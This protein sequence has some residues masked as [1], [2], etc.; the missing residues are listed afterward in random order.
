M[1]AE[2]INRIFR[3]AAMVAVLPALLVCAG[4]QAVDCVVAHVNRRA[5]TL[6]DVR[7]LSAFHLGETSAPG[8]KAPTPR[9]ILQKSIDRRVVI[10]LLRENFPVSRDDVD[11]RFAGLKARFEPDEWRRLIDTFGITESAIESYLEHILQ[12]ER[13]IAIRFGQPPD[14]T[15]QEIEDYYTQEYAPAQRSSGL[16]PQP[17]SQVLGEIEERLKDRK[18]EAQI[19]DWVHGL[20]AQAE[21][22]IN[23]ECL[24][25]LK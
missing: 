13:M 24:Q 4:P 11:A 7:I 6:T 22:S 2:P 23:E 21:I 9:E 12:Y 25:H 3:T 15:V 16:E 20:R 1:L 17:M 19:S 8:A 18:R 14:V 10:E 5:I